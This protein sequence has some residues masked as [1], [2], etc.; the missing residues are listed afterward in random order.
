MVPLFD[1]AD[2]TNNPAASLFLAVCHHA[3]HAETAG[4]Y[5]SHMFCSGDHRIIDGREPRHW[6]QHVKLLGIT[7]NPLV[8]RG[9][10]EAPILT[11][12]IGG[13]AWRL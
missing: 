6:W 8:L 1:I 5:S 11:V 4:C 7:N 13:A 12:G 9:A 2:A 3:A 10:D